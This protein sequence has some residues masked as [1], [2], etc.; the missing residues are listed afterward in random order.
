MLL[1]EELIESLGSPERP[2]YPF[3]SA[4]A[5]ADFASFRSLS[6]LSWLAVLAV[7]ATNG[8]IELISICTF[9][10]GAIFTLARLSSMSTSSP[11]R[12]DVE[13][14]RSPFFSLVP[15]G[16]EHERDHDD[17]RREQDERALRR[18]LLRGR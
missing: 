3:F 5:L 12:P 13:T 16:E 11:T 18:G 9:V 7:G 8:E 6:V 10:P 17:H 4:F 2:T 14:T 1:F 15:P